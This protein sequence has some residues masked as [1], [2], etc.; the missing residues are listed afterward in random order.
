MMPYFGGVA[1]R[2]RLGMKMKL[3]RIPTF[4]G[5]PKLSTSGATNGNLPVRRGATRHRNDKGALR[6][7]FGMR[8]RGG[9]LAALILVAA[10][11]ASTLA[12]MLV[13]SPAAAQTVA[14]IQVEGSRRVEAEPLRSYFSP[15]PGGHLDQ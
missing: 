8:V 9:L 12:A 15:G 1:D 11:V 2:Q 5:L 14:W 3:H 13:S 6:M 7:N 10:P 4:A